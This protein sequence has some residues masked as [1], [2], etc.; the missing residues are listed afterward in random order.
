M[1]VGASSAAA[2]PAV[3]R[4]HRTE[5]EVQR[6]SVSRADL[7]GA[8]GRAHQKL[9]G[10]TPSP[11]LLDVLTAHASLETGSG[12]QM[13][14]FNFGGIKGA[15]PSGET[16]RMRTREVIAGREI[17]VRDGFR[18]YRSLDDG[19]L[20]YVRLM[21]ERFGGAVG[22]AEAGDLDGFA[23]ALK[24]AHYYTADESTYANALQ[25]I[26]AS[27]GGASGSTET[28]VMHV[29]PAVSATAAVFP[30]SFELGRVLDAI[31]RHP[32]TITDHDP[33]DD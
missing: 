30:D 2:S 25:R 28:S 11:A 17:E 5:V 14:N 20:D 29:R 21:R 22:R 31:N 1:R 8:I 4:S 26:A 7:R 6:T 10:R 27:S 9:T 12:A 23:H 3:D 19:A 16:A 32:T 24:Q 13:Y 18:S 15:S 33:E